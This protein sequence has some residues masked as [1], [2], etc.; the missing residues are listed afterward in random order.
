MDLSRNVLTATSITSCTTFEPVYIS[1]NSSV[2]IIFRMSKKL[3]K[4]KTPNIHI[5]KEFYEGGDGKFTF[6][7]DDTQQTGGFRVVT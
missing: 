1:T 6:G 5:F 2:H 3:K 7:V 4:D